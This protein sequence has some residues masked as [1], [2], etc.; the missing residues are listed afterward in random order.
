MKLRH[1]EYKN[2]E[3]GEVVEL[4]GKSQVSVIL[5]TKECRISVE[6][7]KFKTDYKKAEER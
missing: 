7:D 4:I 5:Q 6:A 1:E 2:I 3:T